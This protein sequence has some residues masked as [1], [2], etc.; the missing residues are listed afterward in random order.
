M[1]CSTYASSAEALDPVSFPFHGASWKEICCALFFSTKFMLVSYMVIISVSFINTTKLSKA[2]SIVVYFL[3][4]K[5]QEEQKM[6]S[7]EC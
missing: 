3:C 7:A 5:V 4:A 1:K 6:N 2:T